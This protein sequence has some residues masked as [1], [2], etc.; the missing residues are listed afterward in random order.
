MKRLKLC[1]LWHMHQPLYENALTGQ[2]DFPWV[3]LHA[4]KNYFDMPYLCTKYNIKATFNLTPSLLYQ[5]EDNKTKEYFHTAEISTLLENCGTYLRQNSPLVQKLIQNEGKFTQQESLSLREE[6]YTFVQ[7]IIPYIKKLFQ[8]GKID[9]STSPFHHPIL[10]L[11]IDPKEA[12]SPNQ[13]ALLPNFDINFAEEARWQVENAITYFEKIFGNKP[14]GFWPSEGSI[15]QKTIELF[16]DQ[17]IKWIITDEWLLEGRNHFTPYNY[18]KEGEKI[19]LFFRDRGLSDSIGFH[20]SQMSPQEAVDDFFTKLENIYRQNE[21]AV[22][23]IALDGENAWEF[24]PHNALPFFEEFYSRIASCEWI[25]TMFFDDIVQQSNL[26]NLQNIK[27]GSWAGDFSI[28]IGDA[29]K[30]ALW[31]ELA[32]IIKLFQTTTVDTDTR[33]KA[34]EHFMVA[35]GSDWFWWI[36]K[37]ETAQ[38]QEGFK[39]LFKNRVFKIYELLDI[40]PPSSL[41]QLGE[42]E[43]FI[44]RLTTGRS[45]MHHDKQYTTLQNEEQ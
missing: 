37:S 16:L 9:L 14:K 43:G 13:N 23:T 22:V 29:E 39:N 15:S 6:L 11:L 25:E 34:Y 24:F 3:Y 8:E 4:L 31:E 32:S 12:I 41:L 2:I 42:D 26:P 44:S 45:H 30:N 17:K 28:W 35:L 36:G 18:E 38:T 5:L 40:T 19:T 21:N 7:S 20:Y 27:S 33:R 10:P 1:F